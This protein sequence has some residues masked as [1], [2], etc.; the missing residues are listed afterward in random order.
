QDFDK[1][2]YN[3]KYVRREFL[4]DVRCFVFDVTPKPKTG[5]G[6]FEG[7]MWVEDQEYNIV[8]LNGTYA[9]RPSNA[10]FF[11]MD[12]W[13]LNLIPGYW[14]P[15]YIYSEEGDFSYGS[16]DKMA[17]KAQTRLWGY[18]L[19]NSEKDTEL[20]ELTLDSSVKDETPAAQDSSPLQA[21]RL[22]QQQAE[23]NV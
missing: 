13:R 18:Q 23:D 3:F 20:T 8:R 5:N 19:K 21:Q 12:S 10:Y 17:F 7:R 2:H 1:D 6:R 15:A 9:P 11:H 14:V 4:G 16:K 22:W